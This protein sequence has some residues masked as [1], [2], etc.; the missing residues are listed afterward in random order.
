MPSAA[1]AVRITGSSVL[2]TSTWTAL[3]ASSTYNGQN[4]GPYM[5]SVP[6]NSLTNGS[7]VGNG[8]FGGTAVSNKDYVYDFNSG[9]GSGNIWGC[10]D[11]AGTIVP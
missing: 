4:Y 3:T 8:T 10:S 9:N 7:L 1:S 5:Q 2:G 6:V 11:H